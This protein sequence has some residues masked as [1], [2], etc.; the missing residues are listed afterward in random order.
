MT[1]Q[2]L[3]YQLG[4]QLRRELRYR[5]DDQL[6]DQLRRELRYQL[7]SD[8]LWHQLHFQLMEEHEAA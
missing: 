5:L 6:G 3:K 8:Q 2:P 4:D 1:M 7:Y